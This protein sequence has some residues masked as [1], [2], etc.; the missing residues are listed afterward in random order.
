MMKIAIDSTKDPIRKLEDL[1]DRLNPD[2]AYQ[3]L[4]ALEDV[5]RTGMVYERSAFESSCP[6]MTKSYWNQ[7][8]ILAD[9]LVK[10]R[11]KYGP[12]DWQI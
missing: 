3:M 4:M 11:Y 7:G 12:H 6:V 5:M 2:V 8:E 10:L 1:A 9:R